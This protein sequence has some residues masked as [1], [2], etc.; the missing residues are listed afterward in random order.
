MVVISHDC[1]VVNL[2]YKIE[3]NFEIIVA[4]AV[5]ETDGNLFHGK[6]PR[7]LQFA[8]KGV[9]GE[10]VYE[11]SIL[12]RQILDRRCLESYSP[13]KSVHLGDEALEC[14]VTWI[15]L[16][17]R[18]GAFPDEFNER[19]VQQRKSIEKALK[20]GGTHL[21]GIYVTLDPWG[22]ADEGEDYRVLLVGTVPAEVYDREDLVPLYG[23]ID[24]V[25]RAL[26]ACEGISVENS[27]LVSEADFSLDDLQKH[28][29]LNY[30]FLS[31]RDGSGAARSAL[32]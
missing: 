16:R 6:N 21:S 28:H 22:E 1:D 2:S 15:V 26:E 3:P 11:A 20:K 17:Y 19:L 4:R 31:Y 10:R 24:Q 27:Q 32:S 30:D 7:R 13:E 25:A 23:T 12:S 29:K 9:G 14:L 8:I 5:A 18:R